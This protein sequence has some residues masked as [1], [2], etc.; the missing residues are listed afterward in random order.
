MMT[1]DSVKWAASACLVFAAACQS[2]IAQ[3]PQAAK[4]PAPAASARG[5]GAATG[6]MLAREDLRACLNQEASLKKRLQEQEALRATLLAEKQAITT[7]QAAIRAERTAVDTPDPATA[8]FTARAKAFSERL[9]RWNARVKAFTDSG[10]T[11]RREHEALNAERA[12]LEK[13]RTALEA[14]RA[15]ITA[16][17]Q[18]VVRTFNAKASAF[19]AKAA[20]WN[21]RNEAWLDTAGAI[22]ADRSTWVANCHNRRYREDDEIAI[23]QGK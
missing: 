12:E 8:D 18:E 11:D 15:T 23:R 16:K 4:P 6:P 9:E 21:K 2:A 22:D 14:E 7:E 5:F 3:Q 20:D 13:Q 10:G 1:N 19:D 17:R